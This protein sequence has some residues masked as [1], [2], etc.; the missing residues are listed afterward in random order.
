MQ[1]YRAAGGWG[2]VGKRMQEH[3]NSRTQGYCR[4]GRCGVLKRIG[5]F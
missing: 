1:E 3:E 5:G 2:G 4:G